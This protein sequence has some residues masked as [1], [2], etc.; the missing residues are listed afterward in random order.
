MET[1]IAS[2]PVSLNVLS[3][4]ENE[5]R[6][7]LGEYVDDISAGILATAMHLAPYLDQLYRKNLELVSQTLN[8]ET[9]Q[10]ITMAKQALI[11][12]FDHASNNE[13]AMKAIRNFRQKINT[14]V[15]VLD[16]LDKASVA[17]QVN[18]LSDA[19]DLASASLANWLET[20]ARQN[21]R[22]KSA[23]SWTIL[24]MGKLG[25]GELNFSSDIDLIVLYDTSD[26]DLDSGRVYVDLARQFASIMSQPTADG[27]GWRVD[28]RLRPNPSVTP[29]AIR[30]DNAIS[31]YESMARTWERVA[32]IR[33]RPVAGSFDLSN[34]FLSEIEPFI[35]RRYLDYTVLDEMKMML[36]REPKPEDLLGFNIKKGNGGIRSIEFA[37]HVQQII[38]GG[39]EPEL[40][41]RS[42]IDALTMLGKAKWIKSESA[43]LLSKHYYQLRRLEHRI[44]MIHDAHSH[45]FPRH[46]TALSDLAQFCGYENVMA[47]RKAVHALTKSVIT[48]TESISSSLGIPSAGTDNLQPISLSLLLDQDDDSNAVTTALSELGYN[49]VESIT[50]TCRRWMAGQVPSTQSSRSKDILGRFLPEMLKQI[51]KA[52]HPDKAFNAFAR[53]VENL[54]FGV[55]FF[56]L[57]ESNPNITKVVATLLV[58]SPRMAENLATHSALI[59]DLL[60]E[61]FWQ[62]ITIDIN[63]MVKTLTDQMTPFRSHEDRL[64]HLRITLRH[65]HFRTHVHLITGILEP[66][67][68]GEILSNIAEAAIMV[69]LPMAQDIIHTRHGLLEN[70]A[71]VIMAMGRLGAREMTSSSDL[72]LVFIHQTSN[73]EQSQK[74]TN[75]ERPIHASLYFTRIGQELINILTAPTSEGKAY[76]VDMRLRPSGKSGPVTIAFDRF[77]SYQQE[78]AWT[79]EHMAL[80]RARI[81]TGFQHENLSKQIESCLVNLMKLPRDREKVINDAREMRQRITT[82][83][84]PRSAHDLRLIPGGLIDMDFFSQIMQLLYP[85]EDGRRIG[86]AIDGISDL[87]TR[88][89]IP[90]NDGLELKKAMSVLLDLNQIMRLAIIGVHDQT[91]DALLPQPIAER[92]NI[93]TISE[94]DDLVKTHTETI[95]KVVGKTLN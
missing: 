29:V 2:S 45:Q 20:R 22:L 74:M 62:P 53:L 12:D 51:S 70:G 67:D 46:E 33:A 43:R 59:D 88:Q 76:E 83:H 56:S 40:R 68:T 1:R 95:L 5:C 48:H 7:L 80:I 63:A 23:S 69:A 66:S 60:Y 61:E 25:S 93:I 17:N 92:F 73:D 89:I 37:V 85:T 64:N 75:G 81:I 9:M 57:L 14:I 54:P 79:W 34:H 11:S 28:Y 94:M 78:Q 3:Q 42:T 32:F 19:A 71:L 10:L 35:W 39:R 52:E 16:V 58:A 13:H 21:N 15:T 38:A 84:P 24:S 41:Q 8:I 31:Y 47:F 86:Q 27:I 49:E 87:I 90:E 77:S 6:E 36:Q 18:W 30:L 44:Q 82:H 55:Q 50:T 26:D 91:P 65:W 72:D 4:H